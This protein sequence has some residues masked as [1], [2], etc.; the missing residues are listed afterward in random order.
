MTDLKPGA[1]AV[2]LAH[3]VHHLKN[4]VPQASDA[5]VQAELGA[6]AAAGVV[7]DALEGKDRK[8]AD[9]VFKDDYRVLRSDPAAAERA[10]RCAV[11]VGC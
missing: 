7:Y 2:G 11:K 4:K 6:W 8:Q 3:E 5:G 9:K 10:I 1:M